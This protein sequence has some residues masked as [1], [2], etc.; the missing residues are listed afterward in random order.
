MTDYYA[1]LAELDQSIAILM[2]AKYGRRAS[3]AELDDYR[4][5]Y[6]EILATGLSVIDTLNALYNTL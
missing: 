4:A 5:T 2:D 6:R 3:V 1:E